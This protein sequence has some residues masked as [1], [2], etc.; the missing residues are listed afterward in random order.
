MVF[1][2]AILYL[3][4]NR[5]LLATRL[6]QSGKQLEWRIQRWNWK[7]T[8]EEIFCQSAHELPPSKAPIPNIVHFVILAPKNKQVELSYS[9]FLAIKAVILRINASEIKLH[10]T[11]LDT[12]NEWYRTI[13][14]HITLIPIDRN[15]YHSPD[16]RPFT[17][18]RL[19]HQSDIIRLDI[20]TREGGIYLDKD[21]F[22]LKSFSNL[23]TSPRDVL[24]GHEGGNRY[25][26]CNAVTIARPNS[27]FMKL[28]HQ[29]YSTF[30]SEQWNEHSVRMPKLLQVQHPDLICP[31]SPTTFFWP[32][33]AVKHVEYM[34]EPITEEERDELRQNMAMFGGAMYENQLAFHAVAAKPYLSILTPEIVQENDTRFNVL[35]REIASAP[36]P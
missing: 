30:D 9:D 12:A 15:E 14:N 28:W 5:K 7:S 27:Q 4:P 17:S 32:T 36:L 8:A 18:I 29:T 6:N 24:M 1:L 25:G 31:L 11:G 22:T 16:G 21:V 26:L 23:L 3:I 13:K 35:V 2:F 19:A 34:H 33:W 20:L 10:T